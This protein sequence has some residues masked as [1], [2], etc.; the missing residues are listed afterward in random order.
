MR[1]KM[2][3]TDLDVI[4]KISAHLKVELCAISSSAVNWSLPDGELNLRVKEKEITFCSYDDE[5]FLN[6]M[7][8][9]R[10]MGCLNGTDYK[11]VD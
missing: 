2:T 5:N 1:L 8:Y 11:F 9:T 7:D 6:P 3:T 10:I 4:A